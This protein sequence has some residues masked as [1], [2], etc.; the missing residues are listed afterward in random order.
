MKNQRAAYIYAIL[1]ILAWSSVSTAFKLSL[2]YLTPLGL[3]FFSSITASA[4]LLFINLF[5]TEKSNIGQSGF[6]HN[7][8]LSLIPGFLNPFLYYLL[9]FYAYDRLRA[10]EAQVLNYTWAIVLAVMSIVI[11]KERF[12]LRDLLALLIS[13]FGVLIISSKG[14]FTQMKFDNPLGSILALSS[15]LVWASY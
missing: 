10:Q 4:F 9:L 8:R 6:F 3:L 2:E 11:L 7:I 14:S 12:R 13:F 1:A 15:S 5:S